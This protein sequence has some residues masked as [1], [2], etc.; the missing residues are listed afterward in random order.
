MVDH[1]PLTHS[2]TSWMTR[3]VTPTVAPRLVRGSV[4]VGKPDRNCS[5]AFLKMQL[6]LIWSYAVKLWIED[7]LDRFCGSRKLWLCVDD[8]GTADGPLK[9][10]ARQ[11]DY[12]RELKALALLCQVRMILIVWP[13]LYPFIAR[14]LFREILRFLRECHCSSMVP[15]QHISCYGVLSLGDLYRDLCAPDS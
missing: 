9:D 11:V 4:I 15:E 10:A 2:S 6:L 8:A 13:L 7:H 12:R 5:R 14:G 3:D 1:L